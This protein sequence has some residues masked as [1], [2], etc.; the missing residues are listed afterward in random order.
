[1]QRVSR[2]AFT[3]G[4][5]EEL[6]PDSMEERVRKK[7]EGQERR[8]A[9]GRAG[10]RGSAGGDGG[11]GIGEDEVVDVGVAHLKVGILP[12]PEHHQCE[13]ERG[14]REQHP[15]ECHG[16]AGGGGHRGIVAGAGREGGAVRCAGQLRNFCSAFGCHD[17]EGVRGPLDHER[18]AWMA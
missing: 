18:T 13:P 2:A 16:A 17:D 11:S 1:M 9:V 7:Q 10:E 3:C 6:A 15:P 4:G 5:E 8:V 14:R 12:L